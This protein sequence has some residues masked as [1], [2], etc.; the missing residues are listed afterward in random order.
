M[1]LQVADL[2]AKL[3][4]R[5]DK[6]S[7]AKAQASI[8][9]FASAT[10]KLLL[11]A[12]GA[13]AAV[14]FALK[15]ALVGNQAF[16]KSLVRLEV[17]SK[18][19]LG[20]S[21]QLKT[22]TLDV[23]DA[24]GIARD[25]VLKGSASFIS[26]TG[27]SKTAG[28]QMELFAK[29]SQGTG[30][31]MDDVARSGAA[32]SQSMGIAGEDFE[33]AFSILIAGGKAGSVELKDV[34]QVMAKLSAVSSN[35]A[36]GKGV[37]ALAD[38]SAA[39]QLVTRAFGG[40]ASEGANA[41]QKLMGTMVKSA[42]K[43]KAAG[44][45]VFS[46][47]PETGKKV[48]RNFQDIIQDIENSTLSSDPT[49][50]AQAFGSKEALAAFEQLVKNKDEWSNLAAEVLN[51]NDV[52]EDYATVS[53]KASFQIAKAW[54]KA[55]NFM[56][57][58]ADGIT[59]FLFGIG[60]NFEA[61][62]ITVLLVAA[63]FMVFRSAAVAAGIASAAAGAK[64]AAMWLLGVAP[65]LLI[66][67]LIAALYLAVQDFI[68]FLQ[69]KDSL[70]GEIFDGP[71]EQWLLDIEKFFLQ[72][73]K[74]FKEFGK[75]VQKWLFGGSGGDIVQRARTMLDDKASGSTASQRRV[76]AAA[77]AGIKATLNTRSADASTGVF[78]TTNP[79]FNSTTGG[80]NTFNMEINGVSD[81]VAA[82]QETERIF[83]K[84]LEGQ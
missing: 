66:I 59:T 40:S 58:V 21:D 16:D 15:N 46:V 54:N 52:S 29:V 38:T 69:G 20:T 78:A 2:F 34:A 3:G 30:A 35:F 47:D 13:A 28:E 48:R 19:L 80:G 27:D 75:N 73:E 42:P 7:Q 64:S 63:A 56:I 45:E 74:D 83:S 31:D 82:A 32:M 57:K 70:F 39:L 8:G 77:S 53:R 72:A 25:A 24:T 67:L 68:S 44:V 6:G 1:S 65:L 81:P 61:I 23:S 79:M 37:K 84:K 26:L 76:R 4:F 5:V 10:K 12:A 49:A 9:R 17:A 22:K 43:L 36:G 71:V 51:A 55:G 18:G 33:K 11:P 14:G 60:E 50:L 62:K 41:L